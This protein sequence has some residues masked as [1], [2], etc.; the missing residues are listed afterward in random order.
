MSGTVQLLN[1]RRVKKPMGIERVASLAGRKCLVKEE[2]C[3]QGRCG[4]VAVWIGRN[5]RPAL[6]C[7]L[8][9]IC[10]L[11]IIHF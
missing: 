11:S 1:H 5:S 4:C 2:S 3:V 10:S 7:R 8:Y 6:T 9:F